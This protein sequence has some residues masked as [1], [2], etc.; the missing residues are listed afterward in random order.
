[1]RVPVVEKRYHTIT[2]PEGLNL[3]MAVAEPGGRAV[4]FMVDA[5]L[6]VV[7]L[8]I[9][10]LWYEH[11]KSDHLSSSSVMVNIALQVVVFFLINGYFA[12]FELYWRGATP[13]KKLLGLRVIARHGGPLT[14][15]AIFA[16]NLMRWLEFYLPLAILFDPEHFFSDSPGWAVF[17]GSGWLLIFVCMP[18]LNRFRARCGDLVA[19]TMV[20]EK[21]VTRLLS[22]LAKKTPKSGE[23]FFTEGQLDMYGIQELQVLEDVLRRHGKKRERRHLLRVVCDKITN[24]IAWRD[25]VPDK[26]VVTFL[27]A[28]YRAQRARLEQRL[29]MGERREKKRKGKLR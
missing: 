11:G 24:K 10:A 5:F 20:V 22:D 21:P 18:L 27:R 19:G 15:R 17:V 16:R 4:A 28:F 25:D 29:L 13:G 6:I 26:E 2:T 9:V 14:T 7:A 23:F 1:M 3:S 12:F 8:F